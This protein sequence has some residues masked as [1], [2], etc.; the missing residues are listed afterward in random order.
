MN[1]SFIVSSIGS[2]KRMKKLHD[3]VLLKVVRREIQARAP[4]VMMVF[5]ADWKFRKILLKSLSTSN[6]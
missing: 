3:D 6:F 5:I 4:K 2:A 1:A